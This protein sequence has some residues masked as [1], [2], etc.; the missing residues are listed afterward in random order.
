MKECFF[1]VH[2]LDNGITKVLSLHEAAKCLSNISIIY[3]FFCLSSQI[4]QFFS[5]V[6]TGFRIHEKSMNPRIKCCKENFYLNDT[7]AC[8]TIHSP[9]G[10]YTSAQKFTPSITDLFHSVH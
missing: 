1:Y 5:T 7:V 6:A 4:C 9:T 8:V 2:N 10:I 3:S